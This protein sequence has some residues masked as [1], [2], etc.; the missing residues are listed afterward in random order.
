MDRRKF[1]EYVSAGGIACVLGGGLW[2]RQAYGEHVLKNKLR[3]AASPILMEKSH[4]EFQ[5]LPGKGREEI[6]AWFHGKALNVAPFVEQICSN[7]F[8]E[9]LHSCQTIDDQHKMLLVAFCGKVATESEILTRVSTIHSELGQE[10]D[11]N[12]A[13]CCMEINSCWN[14]PIGEYGQTIDSAAFE[15]RMDGIVNDHVSEAMDLARVGTQSPAFGQTI[16][17]IGETALGLAPYSTFDLGRS[18]STF[19]LLVLPAFFFRSLAHLFEWVTGLLRDPVADLQRTIS[20]RVSLLGNRIGS[21]LETDLRTQLDMLH[22]WQ[23]GAIAQAIDEY[24]SSA[25]GWI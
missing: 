4:R 6:R 3:V 9:Q 18:H 16:G 15:T 11:A 20:G 24:A 5:S 14:V 23:D 17:R 8:R 7:S 25:I 12:W 13:D 21:E 2:G 10:L 19:N 22:G 1:L